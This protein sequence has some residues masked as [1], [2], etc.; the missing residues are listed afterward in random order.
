MTESQ[1]SGS[2]E[3]LTSLPIDLGPLREI[4]PKGDPNG[5]L[6]RWERWKSTFNLCLVGRGVTVDVQRKAIL[7]HVAGFDVQEIYYTLVGP[8][9]DKDYEGTMKVLDDYFIPKINVSFERHLFR[10]ISRKNDETTDQFVCRLRQQASSCEFRENE[11][12]YIRDQLIDKCYSNNLRCKFLEKTGE[13]KLENLL[14]T[15]RAQEA[16]DCQIKTLGNNTEKNEINYVGSNRGRH[17]KGMWKRNSSYTPRKQCFNCGH[18]GHFA[19]DKNCPAHGQACRC[20]G[21]V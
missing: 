6:Q 5:V 18:Q 16:V 17:N 14:V 4:D 7:L 2:L 21:E 1:A 8:E 13:V 20:C 15:A 3:I 12:D 19:K 11:D 9:D 10:Q